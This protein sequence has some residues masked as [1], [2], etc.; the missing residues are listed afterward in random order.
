P[1]AA[2]IR[3]LVAR[4]APEA[5]IFEQTGRLGTAH[6]VLLAR[7][8]ISRGCDDLLVMFGDTPPVEPETLTRARQTIAEGNAVAVMGFRT[9]RPA[10]YGRLI[11][12]G[13]E[14]I[15]IREDRDCTAEERTI[16]FCNSGLMGL[17]GTRALAILERIGNVNAKGEYYL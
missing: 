1:D 15:A 14:L 13:G 9:G 6:A 7:E 12:A 17:D 8:A 3:A 10:G 4:E 2:E 5:E 16:T 11:E